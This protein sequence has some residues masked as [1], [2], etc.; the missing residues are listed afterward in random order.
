MPI[1]ISLIGAGGIARA[2]AAAADSLGQGEHGVRIVAVVDPVETA[3]E[4]LAKTTGGRAF[5]DFSSL[6]EGLAEQDQPQAVIVCTPPS[7]RLPVVEQA[8][9]AGLG[10]LIEKPPAHTLADARELVA[11]SERF[12]DQPCLVGF[13]HRFTPAVDAMIQHVAA[14]LIG[15]VVRF[16]NTFAANLPHLREAWMSD[17]LRSGGGSLIDTGLHSLD[18]FRYLFGATQL[19]ARSCAKAGPGGASP[20]PPCCWPRKRRPKRRAVSRPGPPWRG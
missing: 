17:P 7:A 20:T 3:R 14:G 4:T 13:C 15:E 1:N 8:L 12:A 5:A 19:R 9:Q 11:L 6:R 16:E 10:V 2:H 18:L